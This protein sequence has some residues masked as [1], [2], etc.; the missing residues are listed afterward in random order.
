MPK[1]NPSQ[2]RRSRGR[3]GGSSSNRISFN[4]RQ[5]TRPAGVGQVQRDP[6]PPLSNTKLT[7]SSI[8]ARPELLDYFEAHRLSALLFQIVFL[9]VV[10]A[11]MGTLI[12]QF[13]PDLS[14]SGATNGIYAAGVV[15][16]LLIETIHQWLLRSATLPMESGLE[17]LAGVRL[18]TTDGRKFRSY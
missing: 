3:S 6:A 13:I 18:P 2:R 7:V 4:Q 8:L 5:P 15:F 17:S 12:V 1:K 9:S 11:G 10:I 14:P 16:L